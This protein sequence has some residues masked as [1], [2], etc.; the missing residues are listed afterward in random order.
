[1]E[2]DGDDECSDDGAIVPKNNE[3]IFPSPEEVEQSV[4][5]EVGMKFN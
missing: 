3:Y 4:E 5:P 1:M 2:D